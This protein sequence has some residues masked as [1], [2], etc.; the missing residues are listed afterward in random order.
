MICKHTVHLKL[1]HS[2]NPVNSV[3]GSMYIDDGCIETKWQKWS[4]GVLIILSVNCYNW[5]FF[6]TLSKYL[7]CK[8]TLTLEFYCVTLQWSLN[9]LGQVVTKNNGRRGVLKTLISSMSSV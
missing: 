7:Y 6:I 1:W 4:F 2:V 9:L 3:N 8:L 5:I